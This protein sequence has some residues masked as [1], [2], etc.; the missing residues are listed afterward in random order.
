M[1]LFHYSSAEEI[2]YLSCLP[3]LVQVVKASGLLVLPLA[4]FVFG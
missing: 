1:L 4:G 3:V 2:E